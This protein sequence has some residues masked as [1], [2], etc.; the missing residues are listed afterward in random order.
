MFVSE[1]WRAV[2][3]GIIMAVD[4][5]HRKT[6]AMSAIAVVGGL[7]VASGTATLGRRAGLH[8]I[9]R[10]FTQPLTQV[11]SMANLL[12]SGRRVRRAG[13]RPARRGRAEPDPTEPHEVTEAYGRV[14]FERVS[15]RYHPDQRLIEELFP[16]GRTRAHGRDR[17]PDGRRKDDPGQPGH[18]GSTSLMPAGSPS[19]ASTSPPMSRHTLRSEIAGAAGHLALR[20][21]HPETSPTAN[22]AATEDQILAAAQATFV[23][24][25]V[26]SLPD[27]YDTVMTRRA[28]MSAPVRS[29]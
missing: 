1:L 28:A 17:G 16:G 22:P 26:R 24:R 14:E 2:V 12:Q 18:C 7:R 5:V 8:S 3:S 23:D 13:F 11:A 4:D 25:F 9:S 29:N 20:R 10:Q 6:S 15:F 21:H 27:G 19:T